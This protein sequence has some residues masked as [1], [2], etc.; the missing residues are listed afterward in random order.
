MAGPRAGA[1]ALV[2]E[3]LVLRESP[4]PLPGLGPR[5]RERDREYPYFVPARCLPGSTARRAAIMRKERRQGEAE[6]RGEAE[7]LGTLEG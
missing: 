2:M 6:R 5:G 1:E 3:R 4:F 7:G